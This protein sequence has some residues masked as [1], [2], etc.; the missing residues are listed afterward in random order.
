MLGTKKINPI[1]IWAAMKLGVTTEELIERNLSF[2][3]QQIQSEKKQTH[4]TKVLESLVKM[5]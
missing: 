5:R 3:R 1:A 4:D 2:F